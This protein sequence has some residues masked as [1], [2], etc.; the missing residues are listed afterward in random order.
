M[1]QD[2]TNNQT[3]K[4]SWLELFFDLVFVVAVSASTAI[5][6][7]DL[8]FHGVHHFIFL[9]LPIWWTW[10]GF[11]Y[12]T[13][14]FE[15]D[16][17][18]QRLMLF[19]VMFGVLILANNVP[20]TVNDNATNFVITYVTLQVLLITMYIVSWFQYPECNTLTK[21]YIIGFTIG[22]AIWLLSLFFPRSYH[23]AFWSTALFI[24]IAT[25]VISYLTTKN[26]P[27]Q[28]SHMDERFGLFT[29]IV[30]G[31]T[32]VSVALGIK[33]I[34]WSLWE[35][36]NSIGGFCCA[37]AM[38][39]LYFAYS[40]DRVIH[41][42]LRGGKWELF[43][44]FIYGYSHFLIFASIPAFG[45]AINEYIK[46][47]FASPALQLILFGSP[48]LYL[49]AL[50]IIQYAAC[51]TCNKTLSCRLIAILAISAFA[52]F[53]PATLLPFAILYVA[54]MLTILTIAESIILCKYSD[55]K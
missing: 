48:L 41:R 23:F 15:E 30:L 22:A 1:T 27:A 17:I 29:L 9:F 16:T 2:E 7:G 37:I 44:S 10:M 28:V 33:G 18:F 46:Q 54:A 52:F 19:P 24:E 43:W 38:W 6:H 39:K 20:N 4:A 47:E 35:V 3:R 26:I 49:I 8:S 55:R 21:R 12:F 34:H 13:D 40:D 5:L 14:Q 25:P 32:I 45:V 51:N 31:D 42:A 11:S 50:T 53:A 36:L